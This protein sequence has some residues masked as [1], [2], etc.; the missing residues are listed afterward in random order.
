MDRSLSIIEIYHI[1]LDPDSFEGVQSQGLRIGQFLFQHHRL[2]LMYYQTK[3]DHDQK[4]RWYD[5]N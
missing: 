5:W 2:M 3:G 4:E 1:I